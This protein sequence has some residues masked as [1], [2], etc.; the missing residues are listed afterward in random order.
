VGAHEGIE[1]NGA[2]VDIS[3]S[4]LVSWLLGWK[5]RVFFYLRKRCVT[6]PVDLS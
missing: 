4:P 2:G 5:K 6:S 3:C 1:V